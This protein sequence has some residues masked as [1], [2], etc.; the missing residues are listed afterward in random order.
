VDAG[1]YNKTHRPEQFRAEAAVVGTRVQIEADLLAELLG[2]KS[3]AFSVGRVSAVLAELGEAGEGLLDGDLEVVA[4]DSLM[5]RDGLVIDVAAVGGVGDGNGDAA[6][7]L[8]VRG[9]ALIVGCGGGLERRDG[10]TV[11]AVFGRRLKSSGRWG[12]IWAMYL[13]KSSTMASAETARY[14]GSF[15]MRIAKGGE[16]PVAVGLGKDGHFRGVAN[17]PLSGR[18]RGSGR[19]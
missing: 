6:G 3:P 8:S 1:V 13:R 7:T 4:R 12:C 19:P 15:S 17:R 2:V 5:I 14:L 10:S 18:S 16:V 9:S 11:T